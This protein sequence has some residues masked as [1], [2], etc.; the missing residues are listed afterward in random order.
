LSHD[1]GW[2]AAVRSL[3]AICDADAVLFVSNSVEDEI[4]FA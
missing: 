1:H 3:A 2:F 4:V